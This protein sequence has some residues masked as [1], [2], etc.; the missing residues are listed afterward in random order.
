[1]SVIPPENDSTQKGWI[2]WLNANRFWVFLGAA[3]GLFG[4]AVTIYETTSHV[5]HYLGEVLSNQH[6]L[7]GQVHDK[8]AKR[9][10]FC[11]GMQSAKNA[12][13]GKKKKND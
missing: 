10:K 6:R 9:I 13:T 5:I 12:L 1:M 11:Y 3:V 2:S 7:V 8:S 4:G